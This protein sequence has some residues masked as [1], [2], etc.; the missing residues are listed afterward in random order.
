MIRTDQKGKWQLEAITI[1]RFR[2]K[3]E[4]DRFADKN[5]IKIVS[6]IEF[7]KDVAYNRQVTRF[8]KTIEI[9]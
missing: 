6:V 4:M 9:F 3:R 2:T 5:A 1:H 8:G 7:K